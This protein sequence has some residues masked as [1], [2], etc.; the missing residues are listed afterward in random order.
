[1]S[2]FLQRHPRR[3]HRCVLDRPVRLVEEEE[4]G[5][6]GLRAPQ[7]DLRPARWIVGPDVDPGWEDPN[8][9]IV[10]Y[11]KEAP[12]RRAFYVGRVEEIGEEG[13]PFEVRVWERPSGRAYR[14][15][16][17]PRTIEKGSK[18]P[19][20]GDKIHLWTWEEVEQ[21]RALQVVELFRRLI[22]DEDREKWNKIRGDI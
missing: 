20:V 10:Q 8:G 18:Q 19:Q 7:V 14:T 3:P 6:F 11:M 12:V 22:T 4:E 21:Q 1:M 15:W 5:R 2:E 16:L 9:F 17:E 13:G